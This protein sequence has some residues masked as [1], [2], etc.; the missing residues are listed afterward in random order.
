M[1]MAPSA[2][3]STTTFDSSLEITVSDPPARIVTLGSPPDAP[4]RLLAD[5]GVHAV[6]APKPISMRLSSLSR[7][8]TDLS[9]FLFYLSGLVV[10]SEFHGALEKLGEVF[11]IILE[12]I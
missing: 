2:S 8:R 11:E 9:H 10:L 12:F 4:I 3:P 5:F 7:G 6:G 1:I